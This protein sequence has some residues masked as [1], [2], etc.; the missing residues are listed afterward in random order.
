MRYYNSEEK[1]KRTQNNNE[2]QTRS[3]LLLH[4]LL[5]FILISLSFIFFYEFLLDFFVLYTFNQ[6]FSLH[7]LQNFTFS[8][9]FF[10]ARP[11]ISVSFWWWF[12]QCCQSCGL[13]ATNK[14]TPQTT[15]SDSFVCCHKSNSVRAREDKV[16]GIHLDPS[17]L[18]RERLYKSISVQY[19]TCFCIP[20]VMLST[21]EI[22]LYIG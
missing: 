1:T 11:L 22:L 8:C 3:L 7:L 17:V 15:C 10:L 4:T 18:E 20:H 21:T 16:C 2:N 19:I 14:R 12:G 6:E 13:F 5:R 9:L